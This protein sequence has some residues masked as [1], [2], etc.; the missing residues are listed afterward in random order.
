M[1]HARVGVQANEEALARLI[2]ELGARMF[3]LVD[4]NVGGRAKD[5]ET[6]GVG[7]GPEK[8]LVRGKNFTFASYHVADGRSMENSQSPEGDGQIRLP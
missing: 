5:P 8:E 4:V 7:L 2:F 1:P 6:T 3:P